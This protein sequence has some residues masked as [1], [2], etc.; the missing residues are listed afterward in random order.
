LAGEYTNSI[1]K[2][3]KKRGELFTAIRSRL[4]DN[5]SF[6]EILALV[7]ADD[8]E[9]ASIEFKEKRDLIGLFEEVALLLN[10]GLIRPA[11][12]NY[13][14]GYYAIR[15]WNNPRFWNDV[16]R[17]SAYWSLYRAFVDRMQKEEDKLANAARWRDTR[18]TSALRY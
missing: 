18:F 4:K 16:R 1:N 6:K 8:P 9:L 13:M 3:L 12:A 7:D 5:K 11:V 10:S 17:E 14:F 2:A 15:C